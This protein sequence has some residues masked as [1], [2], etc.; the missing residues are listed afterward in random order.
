MCFK[1]PGEQDPIFP[2]LNLVFNNDARI[3]MT[4]KN[5]Q[6][7]STI[8]KLLLGDLEPTSGEILVNPRLRVGRFSQHHIDM[9]EYG[10]T[11]VDFLR[12]HFPGSTEQEYRAHL[13]RYG[14]TGDLGLNEISTL[15]GGQKSR[16]VF[17][18]MSFTNPHLLVL[19]EPEN[20]LDV[21]TVDA[22]AVALND[23]NGAVIIVSHDERLV[24]LCINTMWICHEGKVTPWEH[25][26]ETYRKKLEKEMDLK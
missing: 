6:G 19:D 24:S 12:K 7:K 15:S 20:H 16:L 5:G 17:A 22:L 21:D 2:N 11:C 18:W 13:G 4:G 8:L 25:D 9:L 1:Y 23:Y 26:W 3:C 14:L 10:M